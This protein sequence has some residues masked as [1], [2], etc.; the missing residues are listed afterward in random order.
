MRIGTSLV[1]PQGTQALG[2][3]REQV[4]LAVDDGFD[5][6]WMANIFG[7]DALT[8]LAVAG[9][10]G[11]DL[12]IGT[13]VAAASTPCPRS[14]LPARGFPTSN[15]APR[16]CRPTPGTRR[17]WPSRRSPPRWRWTA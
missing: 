3:L 13:A 1:E 4:L 10:G 17:R 11:P 14:R 12:E 6:A 5:S 8:A 7:L 9:Q 15:S 2:S 16:W